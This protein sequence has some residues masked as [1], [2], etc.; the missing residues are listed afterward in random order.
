[1]P[2]MDKLK[3]LN[4]RMVDF[5]CIREPKTEDNKFPQ[6]LVAFGRYA[7]I[8]GA[9]DFLRGIGEFLLQKQFQ[10]PFLIGSSYMYLDYDS[11]KFALARLADNIRAGGLP[12]KLAPMVFAVTGTGRVAQG[13][14]EVLE[15]LPHVKVPPSELRAYLADPVNA[16]N[17]RQIIISIFSS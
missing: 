4:I 7:G 14:V 11:M 12:R 6:R 2:L 13:S 5:E 3:E 8:A 1:M 16:A 9:F 17:N 10:T 15:Q